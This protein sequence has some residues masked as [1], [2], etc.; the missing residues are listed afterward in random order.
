M[1]GISLN[2]ASLEEEEELLNEEDEREVGNQVNDNIVFYLCGAMINERRK[3]HLPGML[4]VFN[5]AHNLP[6]NLDVQQSTIC[7]DEG[8]LKYFSKN[9]FELISVVEK[10]FLKNFNCWKTFLWLKKARVKRD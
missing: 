3:K 10:F 7:R 2:V 9:K 1:E 6:V 5:W 8:H 4:K